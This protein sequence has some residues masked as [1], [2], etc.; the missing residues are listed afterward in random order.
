V[1]A[2]NEIAQKLFRSAERVIAVLFAA[3]V[4]I[5][6]VNIAIPMTIPGAAPLR[7]RAEVSLAAREQRRTPSLTHGLPALIKAV[8]TVGVVALIGR[9][10]FRLRL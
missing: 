7:E 5:A 9:K 2:K 1:N 8:G 6:G 10:V 3:G 4:V